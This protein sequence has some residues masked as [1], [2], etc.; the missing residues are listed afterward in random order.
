VTEKFK[1]ACVFRKDEIMKENIHLN[2]W[3]NISEEL[4]YHGIEKEWQVLR[5]KYE[6][7]ETYFRK[8]LQNNGLVNNI[9]WPHY[10]KFCEIHDIEEDFELLGEVDEGQL[11]TPQETSK[12]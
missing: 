3:K 7:M 10:A 5:V 1:D 9:P 6:N 12:N 2:V 4:L 8:L 11:D